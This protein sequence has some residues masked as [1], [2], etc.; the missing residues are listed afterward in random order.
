VG[1]HSYFDNICFTTHVGPF[2][3]YEPVYNITSNTPNTIQQ[4]EVMIEIF[5]NIN[6]HG[7]HDHNDGK[8]NA[9]AKEVSAL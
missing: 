6:L 2:P 3:R 8:F 1:D 7:I 4:Y 9:W 5:S